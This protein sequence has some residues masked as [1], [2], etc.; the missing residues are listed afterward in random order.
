MKNLKDRFITE[1]KDS[2]S[3][4]QKFTKVYE[5]VIDSFIEL[6]KDKGEVTFDEPVTIVNPDFY[7]NTGKVHG[8]KYD[9][10]DA[11]NAILI[12][13]GYSKNTQEPIW[14]EVNAKYG[15]DIMFLEDVLLL[16]EKVEE[17]K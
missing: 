4:Y 16:M 11:P 3:L 17:T 2:K 6:L 1:A 7:E 10:N 8:V 12:N 15:I 13:I 5:E 14:E 9:Q